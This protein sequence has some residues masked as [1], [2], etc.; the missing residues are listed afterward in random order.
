VIPE[1]AFLDRVRHTAQLYGWRTYHTHDSRRSEPGFPDLVLTRP[2]QVIFAELKSD[3]GRLTLAQAEWLKLL[4]Q[5]PGVQ[6]HVWRPRDWPHVLRTLQ[7]R[8]AG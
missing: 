3:T 1:R 7:R 2:G 4:A 6:A 8:T 5:C